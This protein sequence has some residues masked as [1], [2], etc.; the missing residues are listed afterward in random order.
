V[1]PCEFQNPIFEM[2]CQ[3]LEYKIAC[4]DN[5]LRTFTG[6]N[7]ENPYFVLAEEGSTIPLPVYGQEVVALPSSP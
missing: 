5:I 1:T 6:E 3:V 7:G 4:R 2:Q